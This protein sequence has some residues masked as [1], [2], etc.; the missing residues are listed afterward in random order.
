MSK[1]QKIYRNSSE[2]QKAYRERKKKIGQ[3]AVSF[4]V[5]EYLY[6]FIEGRP[7]LLAEAFIAQNK[8]KYIQFSRVVL[9][10]R[11][12]ADKH[13]TLINEKGDS[14][15][16]TDPE[17]VESVKRMMSQKNWEGTLKLYPDGSVSK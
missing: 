4:F 11:G 9:D 1:I 16:I 2:K 13:I 8:K 14:L 3:R 7:E 10:G 12:A 6:K 15:I 17:R 5:P